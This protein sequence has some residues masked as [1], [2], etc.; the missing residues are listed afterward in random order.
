MK[1]PGAY[2]VSLKM[3]FEIPPRLKVKDY[4]IEKPKGIL[5]ARLFLCPPG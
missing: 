5:E 4:S 2:N 1:A 3:L